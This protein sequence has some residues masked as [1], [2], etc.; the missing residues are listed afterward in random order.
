MPLTVKEFERICSKLEMVM[1]DGKDRYAYFYHDGKIITWTKRSHQ[2]GDLGGLEHFIRNQLK[3]N[4]QQLRDLRD[5]PMKRE[6]YVEH[7][8]QRGL[9]SG[10]T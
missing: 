4:E 10:D 5:C 7:L 6:D 1:K 8:R 9:I 3:V 2:R